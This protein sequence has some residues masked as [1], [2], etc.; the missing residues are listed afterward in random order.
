MIWV[1]KGDR[2][3]GLESSCAGQQMAVQCRWSLE[4]EDKLRPHAPRANQ[5]G[6][7]SFHKPMA[8]AEIMFRVIGRKCSIMERNVPSQMLNKNQEGKFR[9]QGW[10]F[11]AWDMFSPFL[12]SIHAY[13]SFH[14]TISIWE[15]WWN[16]V[17]IHVLHIHT[18]LLHKR[19][20]NIYFCACLY[21]GG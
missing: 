6:L 7:I 13:S 10:P 12:F 3:G 21:N 11:L 20:W 14:K 1:R 8:Q 17:H 2:G 18:I 9:R 4:I 15:V 5:T 19:I 16:L